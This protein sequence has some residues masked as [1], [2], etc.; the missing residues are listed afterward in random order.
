V[1]LQETIALIGALKQAGVTHFK[2]AD[3]EV[4][5]GRS[6]T[7][8]TSNEPEPI[9]PPHESTQQEQPINK[10]NTQKAE[11]LIEML[12]MKDEQLVDRIFPAGAL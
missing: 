6:K 11:D 1:N 5:L 2:S 3:F 4:T 9:Q 7:R 8:E 12:T 10:E